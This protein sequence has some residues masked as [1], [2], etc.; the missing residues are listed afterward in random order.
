ME[1]EC[2]EAKKARIRMDE[3][4]R[5]HRRQAIKLPRVYPPPESTL[6]RWWEYGLECA[7]AQGTFSLCGYVRVLPGH[8]YERFWYDDVPVNVHGGLT[9]R[10]RAKE[11]G[12]WF[13]FDCAHAWDYTQLPIKQDPKAKQ[14][15]AE[16]VQE[17]VSRLAKQLSELTHRERRRNKPKTSKSRSEKTSGKRAV[18]HGAAP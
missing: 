4:S 1:V 9:F 2:R 17:E 13:G 3:R 11:G 7:V 14:W 12:A 6:S 16:A 5:R 15:D 10:C 18:A 8:P